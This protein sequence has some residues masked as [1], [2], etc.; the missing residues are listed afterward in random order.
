MPRAGVE[1]ARSKNTWPSTMP[2]YQFQHPGR[3]ANIQISLRE[4]RFTTVVATNKKKQ[5]QPNTYNMVKHRV[6]WTGA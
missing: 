2:V 1:P 3:R 6:P 5:A 4:K